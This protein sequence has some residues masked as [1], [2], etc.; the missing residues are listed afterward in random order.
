M[1]S[2]H[3]SGSFQL[4]AQVSLELQLFS[5]VSVGGSIYFNLQPGL[6]TIILDCQCN[7]TSSTYRDLLYVTVATAL[8]MLISRALVGCVRNFPNSPSL[9]L[10][11]IIFLPG[12]PDS[13]IILMLADDMACNP[14]NP[15][16]AQVSYLFSF[17]SLFFSLFSCLVSQVWTTGEYFINFVERFV[18]KECESY[19]ILASLSFE[20][21]CF[22]SLLDVK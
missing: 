6:G 10:K 5:R 15:T 16:S 8:S 3:R 12:I 1:N 9:L 13:H 17:F 7:T 2:G 21:S 19:Q 22:L 20:K 11:S 4:S 18:F 14:R